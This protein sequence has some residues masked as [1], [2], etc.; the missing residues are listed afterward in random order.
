LKER[1]NSLIEIPTASTSAT[2]IDVD[3]DDWNMDHVMMDETPSRSHIIFSDNLQKGLH[4]SLSL[5]L[6]FKTD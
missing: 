6:T 1:L 5:S 2:P 3:E 4:H